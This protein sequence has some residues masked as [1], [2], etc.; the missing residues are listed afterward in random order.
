MKVLFNKF[1]TESNYSQGLDEDQRRVGVS[2]SGSWWVQVTL[3]MAVSLVC[4]APWRT[5]F[6]SN[7]RR[8]NFFGHHNLQK[9]DHSGVQ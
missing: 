5:P 8:G 6:Q 4:G 3:W 2:E 1:D 9:I 7:R